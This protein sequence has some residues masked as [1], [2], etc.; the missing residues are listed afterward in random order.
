MWTE[1]DK[2]FV[3][4]SKLALF[5]CA[6]RK[7][8]VFSVSMEI[9]VFFFMVVEIDSVSVWGIELDFISVLVTWMLTS[10]VFRMS[11]KID[12]VLCGWSKRT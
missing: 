10:R 2:F 3:R 11:M 6:G 4:G 1:I 9:D 12:L 8:R 7:L 5:Q